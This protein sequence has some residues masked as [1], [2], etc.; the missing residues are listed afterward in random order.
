MQSEYGSD[1]D[2]LRSPSESSEEN[3]D[4]S[5]K[6]PKYHVFNEKTDMKDPVFKVGM[7]FKS[8]KEFRAAIR[9]H[10]IKDGRNVRFKKNEGKRIRAI[11]EGCNWRISASTEQGENTFQVK[12]LDEP[13]TCSRVWNNRN[14]NSRIIS[15]M[16]FSDLRRNPNIPASELVDKINEDLNELRR[17]NPGSTIVL[18]DLED[19]NGGEP[20]FDRLYICLEP[21]KRG[22]LSGC[23]PRIGLDGCFL[24]GPNGGQLLT[25]VGMDTNNSIY[26]IAYALVGVENFDNW[27]WFLGLLIQDLKIREQEKWCVITDKQKGLQS[28]VYKKLPGAEHRHCVQHLYCNFKK[29]HKGLALKGRLWKCAATSYV[30]QFNAEMDGLKAEM[31]QH[32]LG[33]LTNQ[34]DFGLDLTS[35]LAVLYNYL[36]QRMQVN[37][38]AAQKM[39]PGQLWPRV[40]KKIEKEKNKT[41]IC[42]PRCAGRHKYQITCISGDQYAVDLEQRTCTYRRWDL[43]GLPCN[44][45]ISAIYRTR[46]KLDMYVDDCC[47]KEAYL[48]SYE[49]VVNPASG[50]NGWPKTGLVV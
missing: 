7:L 46:E 34:L 11:F 41:N 17:A 12:R 27:S 6:Q 21:L 16:Y 31:K 37:R 36:M 32:M 49:P 30:N 45:A 38:D 1:S 20:I 50:H 43:S 14:L 28:A 44:H 5:R 33:C 26:P 15:E 8:V 9:A 24:K 10:S 25:A 42:I 40:F 4:N 47:K 29:L 39:Q 3:D 22:F 19:E 13:H 35:G 23:R 2:G 48:R 18:E